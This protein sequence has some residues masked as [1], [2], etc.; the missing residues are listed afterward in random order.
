MR[1]ITG[2]VVAAVLVKCAGAQSKV[3]SVPFVGCPADGQQGYIPPPKGQ[4]KIVP[5][6]DLPLEA[7]A[8][9]KGDYAPGV[10][11][12]SGWRCRVWIG[13]SGSTVLVTPTPIDTADFM[14]PKVLGQ[15]VEMRLSFAGTSGRFSVAG[16]G[17]R[18][19]PSL[20]ASFIAGVKNEHLAPDSA[21]DPRQYA[22]DSVR[23]SGR[24]AEFTTPPGVTGLGTAELLG[25]SRDP[26]DGVAVVAPDS[27]E[28]DMSILRVR[29][30]ADMRQVEAAVLRLNRECMQETNGC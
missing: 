12:P 18:L 2:I 27:T 28:P 25:P 24:L 23:S 8:F 17:A 20:L 19:F 13:S 15:A 7:I 16:Y 6:H 3:D 30:D 4:P 14:P 22:R 11:A 5:R 10:F 21:F 29:L 9:Y 1:A 26:I